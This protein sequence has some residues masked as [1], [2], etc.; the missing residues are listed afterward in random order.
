MS[1][2]ASAVAVNVRSLPGAVR[3][4]T[5]HMTA[6]SPEQIE[7]DGAS[8]DQQAARLA[9]AS[10]LI[11]SA[12]SKRDLRRMFR[13][14]ATSILALGV[15]EV[16]LVSLAAKTGLGATS[17]A[18]IANAAG[19]V[20]SYLLSR[21]W[22]WSEADRRRTGRQV[23]LY[24]LT[25]LVSMVISS[26]TTGAVAHTVHAHHALRLVLLGSVYLAISLALWVAKYVAYQTV[27][28]R[29]AAEPEAT[30]SAEAPA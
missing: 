4:G 18:L 8:P 21:Y 24:W 3:P 19:T 9:V 12:T 28:F 20:P 14:S 1:N 13:Y 15:S 5:L 17:M 16:C 10:R 6:L 23:V 30:A 22:I 25:S 11:G 26:F 2:D 27:I 29:P 7:R